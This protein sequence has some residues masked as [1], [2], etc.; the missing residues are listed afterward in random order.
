MFIGWFVFLMME[1]KDFFLYSGYEL[2]NSYM[3][4]EYFLLF[5]GYITHLLIE[6]FVEQFLI[7]MRPAYP[8]FLFM[9]IA[10]LYTAQKKPLP[11]HKSQI[12]F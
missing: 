7:M 10:F 11:T 12:F 4:Y 3:F 9:V 5:Y 8:F 1:L 6:S 2:I